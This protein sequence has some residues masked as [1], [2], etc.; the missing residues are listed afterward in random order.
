MGAGASRGIR[1]RRPLS[2]PWKIFWLTLLRFKHAATSMRGL[3]RSMFLAA[4]WYEH[5]L[6]SAFVLIGSKR[7]HHWPVIYEHLDVARPAF[8]FV[9]YDW[10]G[11]GES[12]PSPGGI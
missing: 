2:Q 9:T 6:I 1:T 11:R 4:R 7:V 8:S 10:T 3:H 12:T 5:D